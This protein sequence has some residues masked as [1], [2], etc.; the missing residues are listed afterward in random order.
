MAFKAT[1]CVYIGMKRQAIYTNG[2]VG[3]E[4][5]HMEYVKH[6]NCVANEDNMQTSNKR[7][8][9]KVGCPPLYLHKVY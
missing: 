9:D 5:N 8:E 3:G 4:T 6:W 2:M 7:Q 1:Y